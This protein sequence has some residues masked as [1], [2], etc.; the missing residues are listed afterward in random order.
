MKNQ[1]EKINNIVPVQQRQDRSK[2]A[3]IGSGITGLGCAWHLD[4]NGFDI[5]LF[6]KE[7][8]LG[9]HSNTVQ[10]AD[11]TPID[12]GF[13]V[14]ND[15]TY[16]N[17]IQL[18]KTIGVDTEASDMSFAVSM[19]Q[20][21][22]EYAGDGL[23]SL[24]GQ[25][26]NIVRP[27]LYRMLINLFQFYQEAP[28]DLE[29]GLLKDK[30]LGDYLTQKG[31]SDSF[32]NDHLVPMG[33]AIWSMGNKSMLHFPAETFVRFC[34]NHGLL[35]IKNRPQWRTVTGGSREYVAKITKSFQD[36]IIQNEAV[37]SVHKKGGKWHI[38]TSSKSYGPFDQVVFACHGDEILPILEDP[39]AHQKQILSSFKFSDNKAYLH[40]DK[41]L[42]PKRKR[43]WSSWN[44]MGETSRNDANKP[45]FVTY[46][47]NRLQNYM[48]K[49]DYFVSLNP[50]RLPR[51]DKIIKEI[52]YT[53][54]IFDATALSAQ[55]S[56]SIIQG[57]DN[58]WYGGA[59]CGYG[60]HE[61][62]LS[63]GLAIA[64]SISGVARPWDCQNKSPA[65]INCLPKAS[66]KGET[67][68]L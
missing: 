1:D 40:T 50:T 17:L 41:A 55:E 24:F 42:M 15:W 20:G 58:L 18:F 56:L 21:N 60:F 48:T 22:F 37:G 10:I 19:D 7:N 59:W 43:L 68:V 61:D 26:R 30:T 63:A 6:E 16:P 13:I 49:Q 29:K 62:G 35:L 3:I 8:R 32:I 53:H 65:Y 54:P 47:M 14:Y 67:T 4:R 23:R 27:R 36:R 39:T 11:K 44:Y 45:V 38:Q 2:V 31:Y 9:G 28:E 66:I 57:H 25:Y 12:T 5:H 51:E 46:W 52:D 64:E 34:V 33:S